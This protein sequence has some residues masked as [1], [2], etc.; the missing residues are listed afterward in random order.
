[1][2]DTNNLQFHFDTVKSMMDNGTAA[3]EIEKE[4]AAKGLDQQHISDLIQRGKK[5]Q[6]AK[7][8]RKGSL[9]VLVG[10][11]TLGIG[12]LSCLVVHYTGGEIG[13]PLYGI[14]ILGLLI[15]FSG[16]IFIFQ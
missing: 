8:T 9:L 4:L 3:S 11:I 16:L 10:V 15:V 12:F 2:E 6:G 5:W 7:R 13:L 1:L 14:T